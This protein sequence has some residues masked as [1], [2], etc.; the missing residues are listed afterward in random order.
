[1]NDGLNCV[2]FGSSN[3]GS[4]LEAAAISHIS[5]DCG[6]KMYEKLIGKCCSW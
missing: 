3:R 6:C 2:A 1:V 5:V 4:S